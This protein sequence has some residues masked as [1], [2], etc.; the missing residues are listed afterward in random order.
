MKISEAFSGNYLKAADLPQPRTFVIQSVSME[1]IGGEERSS[2]PVL[3]FHGEQ[4]GL[5]LNKVNGLELVS[6]YGDDTTGWVG[7]PVELYATTTFFSGRQVPCIRVRRPPVQY[8]QPGPQAP[9]LHPPAA[10]QPQQLQQPVSYQP[11]QLQQPAQPQQLQQPV[12]PP[13]VPFDA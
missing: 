4:R 13:S 9:Q 7:Q 1:T 3:R 6:W 12:V 11:Q 5:V 2:K 10:Y 8:Q